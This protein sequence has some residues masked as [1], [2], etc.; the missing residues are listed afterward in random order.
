MLRAQ[1]AF[2]CAASQVMPSMSRWLVG[3]S[4]AMT[5]QSP[6]SNAANCTRRRCPPDSVA[7]GASQAMS[8]TRPSTTSRILGVAGP[9]VLGLVA[10]EFPTDGLRAVEGVGLVEDADP[11]AAAARHPAGIGHDSPG[12]QAQQAGLAVAVAADDSDAVAVV[13]PDGDRAEH[14]LRRIFQMQGLGPEQVRHPAD[15]SWRERRGVQAR[16]SRCAACAMMCRPSGP[17]VQY[18]VVGEQRVDLNLSAITGPIIRPVGRLVATAQNGLEVLRLGGLE[19]GR[20]PRRSR[21]SR[22]CRCTGCGGISRRTAGDASRP[23]RRC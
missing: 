19:T 10:D 21:S 22:A 18:T 14:H 8:A 1:R 23:V 6:I 9:L 2:R 15:L 5:S 20:C 13:D 7:I 17:N 4:S 16:H 12:E 3:S 11:H